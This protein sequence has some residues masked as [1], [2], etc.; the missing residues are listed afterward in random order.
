MKQD[1]KWFSYRPPGATAATAMLKL[2]GFNFLMQAY[3]DCAGK[4]GVVVHLLF[5][6]VELYSI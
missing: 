2:N 6:R 1:G 5:S 4:E 3:L